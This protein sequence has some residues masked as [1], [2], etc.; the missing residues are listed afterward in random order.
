[1]EEKERFYHFKFFDIEKT[2]DVLAFNRQHALNILQ[3]STLPVQ[4]QG[5]Q[6]ESETT[7]Q[8]LVGITTMMDGNKKMVW[9]G[10]QK[11]YPEGWKQT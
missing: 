1:M 9:V 11:D 4:Y 5:K 10:R 2:L 6:I 7:S 8:P 3:N